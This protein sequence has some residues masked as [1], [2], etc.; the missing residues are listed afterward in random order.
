MVVG[1]SNLYA[2]Q[3]NSELNLSILELQAVIGMLI[4]MGFNML[5]SMRLYW[6]D[7]Q[8]FHNKRISDNM[9]LKRFLKIIRFLHL[10]DNTKMPSRNS[11]EFDKLYKIKP[12]IKHLNTV[13]P[14][15]ISP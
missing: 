11:L 5:P 1:E 14:E 7:D 4:I 10:N 15:M 12:M 3:S 6:S 9:P 2:V 8:N 13:F